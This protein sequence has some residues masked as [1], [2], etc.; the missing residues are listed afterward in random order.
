MKMLFYKKNV[1]LFIF[2]FSSLLTEAQL[3]DSIKKSVKKKPGFDFWLEGR[4]AFVSSRKAEMRSIKVAA[5]FNKTLFR[6]G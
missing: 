5:S 4:N 1:L 2:L 6:L 3:L